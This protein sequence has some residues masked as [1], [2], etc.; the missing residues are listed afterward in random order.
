MNNEGKNKFTQL[1]PSTNNI[2]SN[3]QNIPELKLS[4]VTNI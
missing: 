1:G 4:T 3:W 2:V